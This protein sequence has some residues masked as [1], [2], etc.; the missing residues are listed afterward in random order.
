M[1]DAARDPD[2][3]ASTFEAA[4]AR[5]Q[6]QIETAC[7]A[8]DEWPA[9]VAA[10]TR[11]ALD[12]AAAD[13]GA[14][15][16]LTN[17]ALAAGREGYARYDRMLSHFGERLLPGRALS[18][19]GERLPEIIEKAMTGGIAM[20]IAQRLDMGRAAELPALAEEATQFVLTPYLGTE[21]ARRVAAAE[22]G[23]G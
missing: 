17:D 7:A 19:E 1:S 5:L 20:L 6:V 15:Q 3:F 22:A 9:Q 23:P 21:E 12:F 10:G 14:A 8:E 11:A 18:P 2:G 13:P 4:F 16:V